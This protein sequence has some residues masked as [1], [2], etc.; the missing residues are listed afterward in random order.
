MSY[1]LLKSLYIKAGLTDFKYT[2]NLTQEGCTLRI[3]K[4][5]NN[6]YTVF[7]KFNY[8][9]DVE[10]GLNPQKSSKVTNISY[11]LN[12]SLNGSIKE[13]GL[14]LLESFDNVIKMSSNKFYTFQVDDF[15]LK[16]SQ[17]LYSVPANM[18]ERQFSMC[19]RCLILTDFGVVTEFDTPVSVIN[20]ALELIDGNN[21][22]YEDAEGRYKLALTDKGKGLI[23]KYKVAKMRSSMF[24]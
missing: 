15:S 4:T 18:T 1:N 22:V 19:S 11:I 24:I 16:L 8:A 12:G 3:D 13:D 2:I 14:S 21:I 20:I 9:P 5:S 6:L 7:I 23:T 10:I 17:E